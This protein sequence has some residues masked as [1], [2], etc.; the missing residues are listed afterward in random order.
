M[1]DLKDRLKKA[2]SS[3]GWTGADLAR[4]SGVN[5]SEVSRYLHGQVIPKQTKIGKM[6]E[7][8]GVSPAW[9]LGYDVATSPDA[10]EFDKLSETNKARLLAYYRALID[11]QGGENGDA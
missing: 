7:A 10:I 4:A 2:L 11:S 6:A 8:L 5:K 1:E 9:L 3:K